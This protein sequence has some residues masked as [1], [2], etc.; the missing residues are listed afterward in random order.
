MSRG[1]GSIARS[2]FYTNRSAQVSQSLQN[3]SQDWTAWKRWALDHKDFEKFQDERTKEI[4]AY[5]ISKTS[6]IL[7][8]KSTKTLYR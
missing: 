4:E 8:Y 5:T 1:G 6:R 2:I 7:G 3:K